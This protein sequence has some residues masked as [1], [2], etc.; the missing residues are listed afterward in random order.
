ME[1]EFVKVPILPPLI[2][3][4]WDTL[5]RSLELE[6]KSQRLTIRTIHGTGCIIQAD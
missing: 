3:A 6:H 2:E 5:L 4:G 1:P